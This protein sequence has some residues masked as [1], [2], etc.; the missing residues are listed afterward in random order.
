MNSFLLNQVIA[1]PAVSLLV[2]VL[3]EA[4]LPLPRRLKPFHQARWLMELAGRV[5]KP[6]YPVEQQRLAGTL[7][8]ILMLALLLV[9]LIALSNLIIYPQIFEIL[10]LY[11]VM[12]SNWL[13][14]SARTI[15][16]LLNKN[17][18]QSARFILDELSLRNKGELDRPHL[19]MATIESVSLRLFNHWFA[20]AF[21]YLLTGIYGALSWALLLSMSES[22]NRKL[23][24]YHHFGKLV[25]TLVRALQFPPLVLLM[26]SLTLY[27]GGVRGFTIALKQF[28][29]WPSP[30]SGLL[31]GILAGSFGIRLGGLRHYQ[32]R[33][34]NWP[35]LGTDTLPQPQYIGWVTGRLIIAGWLWYIVPLL[36]YILYLL[37]LYE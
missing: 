9:F 20:V 15:E 17:E 30:A 22:W 29:M 36:L 8:P 23:V 12:E 7:L 27:R 13:R 1:S 33:R 2:A 5:N 14:R 37:A 6:G 32:K 4:W 18:L 35:T 21:W 34:A 26:I 16:Q 11:W 10:I 19:V 25:S 24:H 31:L 3:M 28:R